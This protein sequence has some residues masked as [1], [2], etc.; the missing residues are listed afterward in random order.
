MDA[1]YEVLKQFPFDRLRPARVVYESLHL[2]NAD[3]NAA[4]AFMMR[5]GYGNILG[6][7]GKVG[8]SVWHHL[9]STESYN[10]SFFD[11][12]GVPLPIPRRGR[13]AGAPSPV[14]THA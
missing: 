5:L 13:R 6:G 3:N 4:A 10:E 14:A 12:N 8:L 1:D 11:A 2:S 9:N 7:L